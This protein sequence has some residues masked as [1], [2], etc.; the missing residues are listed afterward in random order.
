MMIEKEFTAQNLKVS[1]VTKKDQTPP[2]VYHS[3]YTSIHPGLVIDSLVSSIDVIQK[4]SFTPK[5]DGLV[6]TEIWHKPLSL[7]PFVIGGSLGKAFRA[8]CERGA[9]K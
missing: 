2:V 8:A 9:T 6:F 1:V 4:I 5:G 7:E 3:F